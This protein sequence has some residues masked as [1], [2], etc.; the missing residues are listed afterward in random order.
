MLGSVSL[1]QVLLPAQVALQCAVVK[2]TLSALLP[3][4][5]W[6]L[7]IH[8]QRSSFLKSSQIVS[9][10]CDLALDPEIFGHIT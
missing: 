7:Q 8:L 3:K 4:P 10:I 5:P 1:L 9:V 6:L 2:S